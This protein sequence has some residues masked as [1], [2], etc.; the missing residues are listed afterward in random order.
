MGQTI[1]KF[2]VRRLLGQGAQSRVYLAWDPDLQREVAIK[3]L[4]PSRGGPA[5]R[6][7][8]EARHVSRL[9][10]PNI[11][12]IF[13]MG[14]QDGQPHLV[15][16]YVAGQTLQQQLAQGALPA[17]RAA[18]LMVGVL[19]ALEQA[20]AQGIVHRDL[21]PSNILVEPDGKPR[22]MDFGIASRA[23]GGTDEGLVG[24][25]AYMAPEY[26]HTRQA[27]PQYDIFAAGLVLYEMLS[28]RRAVQGD[29][30]LQA[31]HQLANMPLQFPAEPAVDPRL[32]DIVA[33]AAAREPAL[34]YASA[35]Q[36]REALQAYLKPAV[37]DAG[38]GGRQ[39]T[40]EFLLRRMKVKSDFPA[41]SSAINAIQRLAASDKA[42][43]QKLSNAI[44]KDFALT[45]KMLRLVNSAYY[46]NRSGERIRT[47]S[48]AIVML[49]FDTVRSLA[50]SL[51]LFEHIGDRKQAAVLRE[52]FLRSNLGGM[53][54]RELG[55]CLLPGRAEEAFIC[56][57]FHDLGRLLAHYYFWEEAETIG[58]LVAAEGCTPDAAALRV[59]GI[60]YQDLGIGV[61][62]SWGFPE[63]IIHSMQRLPEGKPAAARSAEEQLRLLSACAGEACA[64]LDAGGD[65]GSTMTALAARF[66]SSLGL[67]ER[68][69]GEAFRRA[70]LGL[71]DLSGTLGI[72]LARSRIGQKL[73][74]APP[75]AAIPP[76]TCELRVD[77]TAAAALEAA[78]DAEAIL[79][80]G[81]QDIS[82]ALLEDLPLADLLRIVAETV[83][84]ATRVRRVLMCLRDEHRPIM[85]GRFGFGSGCDELARRFEFTLGGQDLF[86]LI[87]AKD[88]DVL[89]RDAGEAKV[90]TRLPPWYLE[91][92]DAP[93]FLV[94]P[95]S[96]RGSPAAM[97]YADADRPGA[98]AVSDKALSLLHT[99]R[100]QAVLAIRQAR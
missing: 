29:G 77:D 16:E 1:G 64:M 54:A 87:L 65:R 78:G 47:V 8:A 70:A 44:L 63:P 94:F 17:R 21:K 71:A 33:K 3:R 84:R 6:P 37:A 93:S 7:Q 2:E 82:K 75:S 48:R 83:Y 5:A 68:E 80:S 92:V 45:N 19:E 24:T 20:H 99:L 53:L 74:D 79:A 67:G 86:N 23:A 58:K 9:R 51:M 25:P 14:E 46:P 96:V 88:S 34:R 66:H 73:S 11:V 89:I 50:I 95:M 100:N 39:S 62:R 13:D 69:L 22:V 31:I 49:G 72:D 27:G 55:A 90:R 41:M 60:S 15:F 81:I 32:Q 57:L 35:A 28:G 85:R 38:D 30:A 91:Q 43:V 98:I 4:L 52:E 36:M 12:P 40:L 59:L 10:H 61:A 56:A 26:V 76:A 42:D 97:I 18:E